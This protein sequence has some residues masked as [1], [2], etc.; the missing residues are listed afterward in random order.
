[1]PTDE[2]T[3]SS[4]TDRDQ[5][6]QPLPLAIIERSDEIHPAR[7]GARR[8][9]GGRIYQAAIAILATVLLA[10][11]IYLTRRAARNTATSAAERERMTAEAV[12]AKDVLIKAH[13]DALLSQARELLLVS[14]LPLAWAVRA[15]LLQ[16]D[17]REVG[18]YFRQLVQQSTVSR[19]VLVLPDGRVKVAS[20]QKLEGKL[21]S[22][23]LPGLKLDRDE[24]HVERRDR[25]VVVVVPVMGLTSRLGVIVVGYP[26]ESLARRPG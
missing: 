10:S 23:A 19:A 6:A 2:K 16:K 26:L 25:E 8:R 3:N 21:A 24:P 11:S 22:E 5:D 1:M 4:A 18:V 9:P 12:R 17:Y 20:D 13:H 7:T 15:E 14:S